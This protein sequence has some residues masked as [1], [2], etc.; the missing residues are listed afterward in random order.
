MNLKQLKK[1]VVETVRE[2][3]TK[4][5][6]LQRKA[7]KR[8][9]NTIVENAVTSVLTEAEGDE[10]EAPAEEG[11][12]DFHP[13]V[14]TG[15]KLSKLDMDKAAAALQLDDPNPKDAVQVASSQSAHTCQ[16]L[17]PTQ[18][19]MN[20]GKAVHFSLGML[21]GTM[22]DSEGKG[23]GGDTGAF[24]CDNYLLDGH[25]RWVATCLVAPGA[26]IN[27][28]DMTGV[29]PKEAVMVLNAATGS[30]MGHK[31]GKDGKGSFA[32]FTKPDEIYKIL[33]AHDTKGEYTGVPNVSGDGE[34]TKICEKWAAGEYSHKGMSIKEAT[35]GP[36]EGDEALKWAAEAMAS[37][38][39]NC[40]GVNDS[41]VLLSQGRI[42]MPVAD[43]IKH[44]NKKG[45]PKVKDT[46]QVIKAISGGGIDL[47]ESI[48]LDRWNMLAGLLKD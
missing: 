48:D 25:H 36:K 46:S 20:L 43:D 12:G 41:A 31:V 16:Q 15:I 42:D 44:A 11:S 45:D 21:N 38:A 13:W 2:E 1:L 47:K 28:Y 5:V 23:P 37:N 18:S 9:W 35:D 19:S 32:S 40:P 22:Y 14:K 34:A 7:P 24:I 30:L 6:R 10:E 27:G 26:D 3:Q 4:G 33:K 39:G 8:N 29:T 17:K